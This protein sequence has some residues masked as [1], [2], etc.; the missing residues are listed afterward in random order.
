VRLMP[1]AEWDGAQSDAVAP[2][3]A[4]VFYRYALQ[5]GMAEGDA[6]ERMQTL[7]RELRDR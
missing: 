5:D 2:D 6:F 7:R 3:E 1:P 4:M